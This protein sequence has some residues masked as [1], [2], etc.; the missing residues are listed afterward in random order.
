MAD[1]KPIGSEKLQGA[2]K[3]ARIMEIAR[4]GEA[5]KQEINV[6]ETTDYTRIL[7]DGNVYGIV[8]ERNGYIVKKGI[9][10]STLDYIDPMKNR[11]Y[12]SSYSQALKKL[13]L[14]AGELN[15]LNENEQGIELFGEQKK[16][17]L[18]TPTSSAPVSAPE[19]AAPAPVAP[20]P[21]PEPMGDDGMT[22]P[23]SD[24]MMPNDMGTEEP[25]MDEPMMDEPMM[26][27]PMGSEGEGDEG[28]VTLK[29]VQKLTGKLGQKL[30]AYAS[31][32][33]MTSEDVKYVLN[34][35]LSAVDLNLLDETDKE[36]ILSRFEGEEGGEEGSSYD[37]IGMEPTEPDTSDLDMGGEITA[38]PEV[39]ESDGYKTK[40][41]AIM[42]GMFNESKVDKILSKYFVETSE[43]KK[44]NESKKVQTYIKKK[45]NKVNVMEEIKNL[46]ETIEQELTSEFILRENESAKFIGKTN[47][48]NLI[49]ENEGKQI[50]VSPKGEI[51]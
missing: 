32:Q 45:I 27:E 40:I 15:R 39:G 11:K 21:A 26:D 14:I 18:K 29:Q 38:E 35:I 22:E 13:N 9:D 30:R 19:P 8:K 37:E 23:P 28:P 36:D 16:F 4:Y 46:S 24:D 42:D 17:V 34:S 51:L 43:E 7:A 44:M 12:H 25:A 41:N 31:E 20:A 1:L 10:E 33:E 47:L 5:P 6:N 3:I 50:K 48:K 49:F 2:E